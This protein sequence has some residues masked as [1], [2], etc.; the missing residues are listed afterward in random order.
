MPRAYV[1]KAWLCIPDTMYSLG[2]QNCQRCHLAQANDSIHTFCDLQTQRT[3]S[4][5]QPHSRA[6]I[7][8]GAAGIIGVALLIVVLYY[9]N[10]YKWTNLNYK[11]E[12]GIIVVAIA[13]CFAA[14]S[15]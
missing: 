14:L 10:C 15:V 2:I 5:C 1:Q 3:A 13:T 11:K 6:Q 12:L 9:I 7:T 8:L 4:R